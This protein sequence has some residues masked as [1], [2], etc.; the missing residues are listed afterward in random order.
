[1]GLVNARN[2]K[3]APVRLVELW[4]GQIWKVEVG[5]GKAV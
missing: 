1:V 2:G 4:N 5:K 3:A